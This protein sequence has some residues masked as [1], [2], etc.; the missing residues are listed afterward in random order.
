MVTRAKPGRQAKCH[1]N[2][3]R[4][5]RYDVLVV[6]Y[7]MFSRRRRVDLSNHSFYFVGSYCGY[8]KPAVWD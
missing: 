2:H 5:L 8:R 7:S 6:A 3:L 4:I 1:S